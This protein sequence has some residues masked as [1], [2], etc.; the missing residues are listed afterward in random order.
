MAALRVTPVRAAYRS[1]AL[2]TEGSMLTLTFTFRAA[3]IPIIVL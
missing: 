3:V 1:T 2:S